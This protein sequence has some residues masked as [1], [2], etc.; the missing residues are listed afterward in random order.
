VTVAHAVPA[1]P[2]DVRAGGQ[3]ST[4]RTAAR[5]SKCCRRTTSTTSK[6]SSSR[7]TPT[8]QQAKF[9]SACHTSNRPRRSMARGSSYGATNRGAGGR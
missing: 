9:P 2:S 4:A 6:A 8:C 7:A 5:S 1:G 3:A